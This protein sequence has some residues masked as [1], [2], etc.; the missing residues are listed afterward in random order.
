MAPPKTEAMTAETDPMFD[1]P[2]DNTPPDFDTMKVVDLKMF[3]KENLSSNLVDEAVKLKKAELIAYL[4]QAF[5]HPDALDTAEVTGFD[6]VDPIHK[7]VAE[8]QALA[9]E[10]EAFDYVY[11]L[12]DTNEFN[13]FKMGGALAEMLAKAWMGDYDDFGAFV[14]GEFGFSL[15]KAQN[16][17]SIYHAVVSCGATWEEVKGIGWSKL[18]LIATSLTPENYKGWFKK[19][20]GAAHASVQEMV[21]EADS[22]G[23]PGNPDDGT[24][25][26][27]K[28]TL[29]FVVHEDQIETIMTALKKAKV[30]YGTEYDGPALEGIC[31]EYLGN[32]S[33]VV[34]SDTADDS[35]E[36]QAVDS[37]AAFTGM[38][39]KLI[40]DEDE[41]LDALKIGVD[42]FEA[43]FATVYPDIDFDV[44]TEG[45]P[46]DDELADDELPD[47]G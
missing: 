6:P 28:K 33:S 47:I 34:T 32:S 13:F 40:A 27:P 22:N 1:A 9:S 21:K 42:A 14:E 20:D 43:G 4:K 16:L 5:P 25:S 3:A 10:Q 45:R 23:D 36:P 26:T 11:T 29:K 18:A 46:D 2:V 7:T 41:P 30:A 38:I 17:I 8:V 35:A 44:Y 37:E 12:T 15:R 24:E 31:I 39:K 19:I